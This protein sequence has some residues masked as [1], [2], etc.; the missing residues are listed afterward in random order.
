VSSDLYFVAAEASGDQLGREVIDAVRSER[1]G[2]AIAGIG[3]GAMAGAGIVSPIDTS[4]LS[5]IG[6]IEGI[7]AY[8][9]VTRLADEAADAIVLAKPRAVILI[10]SWGSC[11]GLLSACANA[12]LISI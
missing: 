4:P 8:S 3:G 9:T 7:K 5:I 1:S 2:L 11:S 6:F 10:D 12:R